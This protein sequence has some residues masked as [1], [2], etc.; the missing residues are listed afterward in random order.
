MPLARGSVSTTRR[1]AALASPGHATTSGG[2]SGHDGE[3]C[4]RFE[5]VYRRADPACGERRLLL[6]VLEDGIRAFLKNA[7]ATHGRPL[8]LRREAFL[9]LT[10]DDQ[11]D[12]FAYESIC[13][14]LGIDADRLRQRVLSEAAHPSV[15]LH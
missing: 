2:L 13:E 4:V 11:S 14:A 8:N 12:V 7:R 10:M 1:R 3:I 5:A 6:A 9:W 15:A